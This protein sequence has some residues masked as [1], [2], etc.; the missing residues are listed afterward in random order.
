MLVSS[1]QQSGTCMCIYTYVFQ[2]LL[3]YVVVV[4]SLCCVRLLA[5][6]WTP[7]CQ[8]SLSLTISQCL[9]KFI[10]IESVMLSNHL[11]LCHRLL[12]LPSTFSSIRVFSSEST[13][14]I[15]WP[16]Y[17][18]FSP[19]NEYSGLMS[20]RIDWFDLLAVQGTLKHLLQPPNSEA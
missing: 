18:S 10:S 12:L 11:F 19:S 14:C 7:A 4:H 17:W 9:P 2:I 13:L 15:R 3:A 16:N 20:I 1:V 8:A 5:T 6:P